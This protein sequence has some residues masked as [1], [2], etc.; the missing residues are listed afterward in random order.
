MSLV[1]SDQAAGTADPST[2]YARSA[3]RPTDHHERLAH[4]P[5]WIRTTIPTS[6]VS[7]PAIGRRGSDRESSAMWQRWKLANS[8]AGSLRLQLFGRDDHL[9]DADGRPCEQHARSRLVGRL[10]KSGQL[11]AS[12]A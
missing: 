3:S 9:G 6:K 10:G 8:C 4:S 2:R 11:D 7:C 5:A 1:N 12:R